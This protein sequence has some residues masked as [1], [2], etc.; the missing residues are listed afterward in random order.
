MRA[1]LQLSPCLPVDAAAA[2]NQDRNDL[3]EILSPNWK[4]S[5]DQLKP[6][7]EQKQRFARR[8]I[9]SADSASESDRQEGDRLSPTSTPARR[10]IRRGST[11][12]NLVRSVSSL[13]RA[14]SGM[15]NI[16]GLSRSAPSRESREIS[17]GA[18]SSTSVISNASRETH[19][20]A[21]KGRRGSLN[22]RWASMLGRT[23]SDLGQIDVRASGHSWIDNVSIRSEPSPDSI[24]EE[25]DEEKAD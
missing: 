2:V 13:R 15:L 18:N 1:F 7:E 12:G 24:R 21:S 8:C 6:S 4:K 14:S 23:K 19:R 16:K 3:L 9:S 17:R 5:S 20:Q 22:G 25:A 11:T 10:G